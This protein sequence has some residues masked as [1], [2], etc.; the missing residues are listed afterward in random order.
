MFK[1]TL[2][3]YR[4]S[5]T[6]VNIDSLPPIIR[7]FSTVTTNSNTDKNEHLDQMEKQKR[8]WQRNSNYNGPIVEPENNFIRLQSFNVLA[9]CYLHKPWF[10]RNVF[11]SCEEKDVDWQNRKILLFEEILSVDADI[12]CLQ[13]YEDSYTPD[14]YQYYNEKNTKKSIRD[15][16]ILF[17]KKENKDK[18]DGCAMM[19]D[20]N[21]F[22][23]I[24]HLTLD[25]CIVPKLDITKLLSLNRQKTKGTLIFY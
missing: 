19:I 8:H 22:D 11:N 21:K 20:K 7:H 13:E 16:S 15:Y 12:V 17:S 24:D 10:V 18:L 6:I 23:V 9:N 5:K 25:L 3:I 14:F 2:N 1:L 4:Q